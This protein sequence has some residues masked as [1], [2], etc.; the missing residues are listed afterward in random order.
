MKHLLLVLLG[1]LA[2]LCRSIRG[3]FGGSLKGAREIGQHLSNYH[4]LSTSYVTH[5]KGCLGERCFFHNICRR[6]PMLC[7]IH[8]KVQLVPARPSAF[9]VTQQLRPVQGRHRESPGHR[10]SLHA[11]RAKRKDVEIQ[12]TM[13]ELYFYSILIFLD[14]AFLF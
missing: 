2:L 1:G 9:T 3:K 10:E 4:K 13:M 7:Y 11:G 12:W 14:S 6:F 8:E 5:H